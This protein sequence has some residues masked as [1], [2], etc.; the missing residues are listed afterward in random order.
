MVFTT[1]RGLLLDERALWDRTVIT[2]YQRKPDATFLHTEGAGF[3]YGVPAH[4]LPQAPREL[5]TKLLAVAKGNRRLFH[6]ETFRN[7]VDGVMTYA[8]VAPA[9]RT[10]WMQLFDH[11]GRCIALGTQETPDGPWAFTR[12]DTLMEVLRRR[13]TDVPTEVEL[14]YPWEAVGRS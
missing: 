14:K 10:S 6:P 3:S 7:L 11:D 5:F 2:F 8:V 13:E 4:E 9:E 1:P 12:N